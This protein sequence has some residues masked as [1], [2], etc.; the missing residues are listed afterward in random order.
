MSGYYTSA[1]A[2]LEMFRF[3]VFFARR[4]DEL[5]NKYDVQFKA[6][7]DAIRRLMAKPEKSKRR[8]GFHNT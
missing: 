4:L 3:F 2:L 5:E 7:F 8:I 1:P 6:V